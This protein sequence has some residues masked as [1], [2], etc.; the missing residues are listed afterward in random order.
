[1]LF[2]VIIIIFIFFVQVLKKVLNLS[3]NILQIPWPGK[4]KK[5]IV[6]F[7]YNSL[8]LG[9]WG[10]FFTGPQAVL[11]EDPCHTPTT[12]SETWTTLL[13]YLYDHHIKRFKSLVRAV[14][15]N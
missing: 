2:T 10:G 11:V 6:F 9:W 12:N 5:L 14:K 7:I 3:L 8:D 13:A 1:M 4:K 15:N